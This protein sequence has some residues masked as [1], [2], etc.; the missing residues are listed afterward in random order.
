MPIV[1]FLRHGETVRP[2]A[3][4]GRTDAPLSEKGWSQIERQAAGRTWDAILTS[5]LIRARAAAERLAGARALTLEIAP[6]WTEIDFG[7]WDGHDFAA[8]R[9]DEK[10][11]AM[12][13]AL[14]ADPES[15]AAPGGETYTDVKERVARAVHDLTA[16]DGRLLVMAH[17]GTI[18]TALSLALD[19][20]LAK[21]WSLRIDCGT[22]VTVTL[23]H[24]AEHGLWG[25][26]TEIAQP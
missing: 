19:I 26:V 6:D 15:L 22:R 23:G 16:R 10:T 7:S 1:D 17:G 25:E 24:H 12:L 2:G 21:L 8:L 11:A 3:L 13:Q 20:P 4:L 5:P 9:A 14:Y 18:R